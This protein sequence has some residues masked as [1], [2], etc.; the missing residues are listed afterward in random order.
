MSSFCY[1]NIMIPYRILIFCDI[2]YPWKFKKRIIVSYFN[3]LKKC[4]PWEDIS[5]IREWNHRQNGDE[6]HILS[7]HLR[8]LMLV[9]FRRQGW[10]ELILED[11]VFGNT[12]YDGETKR[13]SFSYFSSSNMC[14]DLLDSYQYIKKDIDSAQEEKVI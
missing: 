5:S 3:F 9:H 14:V 1:I 6:D 4:L 10:Y 13:E 11:V 7:N 12:N 2:W 8:N